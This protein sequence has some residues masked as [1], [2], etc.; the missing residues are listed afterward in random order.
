MKDEGNILSQM[1]ADE[2]P[3]QIHADDYQC[4]SGLHCDRP[5]MQSTRSALRAPLG[6]VLATEGSGR[7]SPANS[8][9][10]VLVKRSP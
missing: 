7:P 9:T 2:K 10:V 4:A 6:V 1:D 8:G 3:S 5:S